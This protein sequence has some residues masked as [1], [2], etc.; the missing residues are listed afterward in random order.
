VVDGLVNRRDLA[1]GPDETHRRRD[2]GDRQ[3]QRDPGR[4]QRAEGDQQD[5]QRDRQRRRAGLLQVRLE[6]RVELRLAAAA[7]RLLDAQVRMGLLRGVHRRDGGVHRLGDL[8]VLRI[9]GDLEGH[10]HRVALGRQRSLAIGAIGLGDRGDAVDGVQAPAYVVDRGAKRR[11]AGLQRRALDEYELFVVLGVRIGDD[12]VGGAGVADA[13]LVVGQRVRSDL[14]ADD[15][16]KDD[17]RDPSQDRG[18]AVRGAPAPGTG[19]DVA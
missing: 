4:H 7:A 14:C 15:E 5:Q 17:E 11:I 12:P 9:P 2:A 1:E 10:Q 18:L 3:Q 16:S 13:G 19:C 6:Y 8:H